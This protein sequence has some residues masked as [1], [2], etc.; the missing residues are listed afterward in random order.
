MKVQVA[1]ILLAGWLATWA[2]T[3]A[4]DPVCASQICVIEGQTLPMVCRD[5]GTI[6][7]GD[8]RCFGVE[9]SVGLGCDPLDFPCNPDPEASACLVL[10]RGQDGDGNPQGMERCV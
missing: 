5:G 9:T 8:Q 1:F 7:D 3:G 2:P 10:G 6:G 4:A